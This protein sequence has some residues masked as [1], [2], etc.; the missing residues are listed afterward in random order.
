MKNSKGFTL[1]EFF[2]V[3]A[4]IG[5]LAAEVVRSRTAVKQ[6]TGPCMAPFLSDELNAY[7]ILYQRVWRGREYGHFSSEPEQGDHPGNHALVIR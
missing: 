5:I 1:T 4:I 3:V 6:K 7:V 2:I